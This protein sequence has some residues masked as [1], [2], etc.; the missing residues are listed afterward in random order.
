M[1]YLAQ[2]PAG[3]YNPALKTPGNQTA[4][5]V[6]YTNTVIQ[7]VFSMFM[8]VG[9]LYFAWFIFMAAFHLIDSQG[10][11]KKIEDSKKEF[12]NG[13]IGLVT[14][15]SLYA[16]LKLIG[17]IFGLTGLEGLVLKLPL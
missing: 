15:F 17:T 8:V 4:D 3:I 13:M 10:D 1:N 11:S 9:V 5:P 2:I 6:G 7:S 12:T 16:I 14:L